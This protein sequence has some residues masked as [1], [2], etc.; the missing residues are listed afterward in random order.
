MN[1]I[2]VI[3]FYDNGNRFSGIESYSKN[4]REIFNEYYKEYVFILNKIN[5]K[6]GLYLKNV[7][8]SRGKG[9]KSNPMIGLTKKDIVIIH[10]LFMLD[11]EYYHDNTLL[12]NMDKTIAYMKMLDLK[13]KDL[14]FIS[15]SNYTH[16]ILYRKLKRDSIVFYPFT[17]LPEL[18]QTRDF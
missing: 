6:K 2:K 12:N 3:R 5:N 8:L 9:I 16:D 4:L 15:N 13:V 7:F 10:D 11:Y 17:K 1:K 18:N 14:S